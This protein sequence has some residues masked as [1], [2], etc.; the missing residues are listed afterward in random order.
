MHF[1]NKK[2]FYTWIIL[3]VA[4]ALAAGCSNPTPADT[5][6]SEPAASEPA[7]ASPEASPTPAPTQVPLAARVNDFEITLQEYELELALF[8]QA[9]GSEIN[10]EDKQLVLDDLVNRHL[11]ASEAVQN[12]FTLDQESIDY[13]KSILTAELGAQGSLIDWLNKYQIDEASFDNMLAYSMLAADMRDRIIQEVP[14]SAE[15]VHARQILLYDAAAAEEVYQQL[16]SGNSF[17]NLALKYDPIT[18]GDLGWF[19]RG[20]LLYPAV[21][22]AV[23][24]LEVDQYTRVIETPAGFHILQLL[25]KDPERLLS[26]DAFQAQQRRALEEWLAQAREQ[27]SIEVLVPIQ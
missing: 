5:P 27:G 15:Q 23:F 9:K 17:Q 25:E 22:D 19:P 18:G 8:Q 7:P 12:G 24:S 26:P 20:Y 21:E 10:A 2:L 3:G 6:A 14:T 13:R 11:L 1:W 4:I 16:Q